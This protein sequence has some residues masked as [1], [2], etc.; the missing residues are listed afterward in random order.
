MGNIEFT[1]LIFQLRCCDVDPLFSL[2]DQEYNFPLFVHPVDE[3]LALIVEVLETGNFYYRNL[4][5]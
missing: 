2:L 1:A 4:I 3:V 5:H